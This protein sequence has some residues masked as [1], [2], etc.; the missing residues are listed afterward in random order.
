MRRSHLHWSPRASAGQMASVQMGLPS[1][2]GKQVAPLFGM[3][4][5]RTPMQLL[6]RFWQ[7]ER[8]GRWLLQPRRRR[9]Q[10]MESWL[11]LTMWLHWRSRHL[12][13]LAQGLANFSPNWAGGWSVSQGIWCPDATWSSR[14]RLPCKEATLPQCWAPSNNAT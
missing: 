9:P 14:F 7:R 11:G 1:L 13:H 12:V 4:H 2:H 3:W 6:I 8:R 10:S 5:A